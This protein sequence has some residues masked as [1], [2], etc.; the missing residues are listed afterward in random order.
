L[1][2]EWI[3]DHRIPCGLLPVSFSQTTTPH[4]TFVENKSHN[5]IRKDC[6]KAVEAIFLVVSGFNSGELPVALC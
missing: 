2:S 1:D 6:Q 3:P 4:S 5:A